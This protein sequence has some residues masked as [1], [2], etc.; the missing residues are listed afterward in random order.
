LEEFCWLTAGIQ[1]NA[2][3]S[4]KVSKQ[5]MADLRNTKDRSNSSSTCDTVE[6][7]LSRVSHGSS[8][9]LRIASQ[10]S[11]LRHH[12]SSQSTESRRVS[13]SNLDIFSHAV[14]LGD[15]PSVSSGPPLS[16]AWETLEEAH[17][18]VDEYEAYRVGSPRS[19]SQMLTPARVREDLLR[20]EGYARKDVQE[21][22][23][24]VTV[25]REQR[26]KSAHDGEWKRRLL[27]WKR[28][29]FWRN[30]IQPSVS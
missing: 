24:Q 25:I 18:S 27:P 30:K 17:L 5:R 3:A 7:E 9:C 6:T 8:P 14:V 12:Y 2:F 10:E 19:K 15:N 20:S 13:F 22:I 1:N 11:S 28:R 29:E 23:K 16:L 26:A 4:T 21:V